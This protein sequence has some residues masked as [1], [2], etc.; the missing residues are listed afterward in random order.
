[1]LKEDKAVAVEEEFTYRDVTVFLVKI[2]GIFTC[3]WEDRNLIRST[4]GYRS[5]ERCIECLKRD[6]DSELDNNDY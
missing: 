3:H 2:F 5:K 4:E 6:I 1:M